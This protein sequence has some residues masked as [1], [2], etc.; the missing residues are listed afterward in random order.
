MC[1]DFLVI[2][3]CPFQE[4]NNQAVQILNTRSSLTHHPIKTPALPLAAKNN[5]ALI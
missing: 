3:A 5:K 4:L 1:G 2:C